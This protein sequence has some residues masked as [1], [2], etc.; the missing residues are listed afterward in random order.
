MKIG[1]NNGE[2]ASVPSQGRNLRQECLPRF[3]G[4]CMNEDA[5]VYRTIPNTI[6]VTLGNLGKKR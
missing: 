1:S 6:I 4:W 5:L 2:M 3:P